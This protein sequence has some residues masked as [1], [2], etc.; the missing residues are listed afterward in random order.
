MDMWEVEEE[1]D[2]EGSSFYLRDDAAG[3]IIHRDEQGHDWRVLLDWN[4]PTQED[5]ARVD[6]A[7]R[8]LEELAYRF[9]KAR[10]LLGDPLELSDYVKDFDD[11]TAEAIRLKLEADSHLK[12]AMLAASRFDKNDAAKHKQAAEECEARAAFMRKAVSEA[13]KELPEAMAEP[14]GKA[15]VWGKKR[16]TNKKK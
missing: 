11:A 15:G 1:R 10:G 14:Q 5:I 4:Y 8:G 9:N 16:L 2:S 13:T 12:N 3:K 7:R 6:D